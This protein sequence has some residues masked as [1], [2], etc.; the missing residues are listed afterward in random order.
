MAGAFDES[1]DIGGAEDCEMWLRIAR[2]CKIA[3]IARPLAKYRVRM[4]GD[5]RSNIE[6]SY[7]ASRLVIERHW[8][9]LEASGHRQGVYKRRMHKF[10]KDRGFSLLWINNI[11]RAR[12]SFSRALR[13]NPFDIKIILY[14]AVLSL[15]EKKLIFLKK[16]KRGIFKNA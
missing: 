10:Y 3:Y 12:D 1:G 13:Y 11:D 6:R 9:S 15:P 16:M 2:K 5:N 7:N 4:K 14:C 8:A